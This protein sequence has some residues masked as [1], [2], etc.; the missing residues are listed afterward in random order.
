[1][2][3]ESGRVKAGRLA[4]SVELLEEGARRL[5]RLAE[6]FV[7]GALGV[8]MFQRLVQPQIAPLLD[9]P[10]TRL[11]GL[12]AILIAAGLVALRKY[13]VVTS[14]QLLGVGVFF[15][16]AVA[17]A[18]AMVETSRPFNPFIP[19]L[20][21]SAI[22]AWVVFVA[23][24]IPTPPHI[25]LAL[26]LAAATMWPVAYMF[27]SA[28]FGFFT[29]SWRQT[30]IWPA[31][32]YLFA[33]VAYV[34]G[35]LTFGT[36]REVQDAR[37]LGS[38]TLMSQIGEGGMG[39]VWRA[40][41]KLLARPAA[42][43]LVK[44][45]A[46]RQELFAHRF[47]REAN[48]I[49]ALKS[50]HTVYLYDFGTTQDGRLYYV[51][52]LLDGISLQTLVDTFGP[53]PPSRVVALLKQICRSL[54]EAHQEK[55]VHRDLKPS[56]VMICQV[57]Q[58]RDF[59]KVLDFGLAKPFGAGAASNL[60]VEGSTLGTPEYMAPEVGRGSRAVDARADLYA[61]GCVAYVLVT[62]SLVF[63]DSNPV[64]VALK[65][66]RTPPVP[67]SRRTERPVPPD[68][69]RVILACLE[70]DPDARPGSA[71]AVERLLTACNVPPWTEEDADAWWQRHLPPTSPLRSFSQ[72]PSRT[73]PLVQKA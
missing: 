3:P 46:S 10:A 45:D 8:Y 49:A 13:S 18:I 6:V 38:Y 58:T 5:T 47:H 52:E 68:L 63:T 64:S 26:A 53:Q 50:P 15:E 44:L 67:P 34:I 36:V 7:V 22:G 51:M 61:L 65:H 73:L 12:I 54:E 40:T 16:I 19:L 71:R 20:G 4:L 66:M 69:E 37:N 57:A 62:G 33:F 2:P 25:R 17:F 39:E 72:A 55:I 11:A 43:K 42:I 1:M 29:E 70:K 48:A 27:N 32:N 23:A 59:V 24:V 31:M 21:L 28:R 30:S 9:D 41:H 35:R 56:N 60:T 14:Q